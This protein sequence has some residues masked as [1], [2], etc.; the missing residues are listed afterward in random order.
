[1]MKL[2]AKK[3]FVLSMALTIVL[4]YTGIPAYKM[5]CLEDGHTTLTLSNSESGCDHNED[6]SDCC[7]PTQSASSGDCCAFENNFLKLEELPL[8]KQPQVTTGHLLMFVDLWFPIFN[9]TSCEL[10]SHN[11]H[12]A[13]PDSRKQH[14]YRTH[15]LLNIFRI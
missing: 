2:F 9:E 4:G 8:V 10:T 7:K 3:L 14:K 15:T 1:M 12:L 5:I 11:G 13:A 6:I